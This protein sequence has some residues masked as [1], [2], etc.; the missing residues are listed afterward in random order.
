MSITAGDIV[1]VR[2]DESGSTWPALVVRINASGRPVLQWVARTK[3]H[4]WP[5]KPRTLA[6]GERIA[7]PASEDQA[8]DLRS[9]LFSFQDRTVRKRRQ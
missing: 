3:E 9:R 8:D 4:E 6:R 1:M 2:Q 7:G 5:S